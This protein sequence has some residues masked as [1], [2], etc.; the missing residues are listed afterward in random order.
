MKEKGHQSTSS[1]AIEN[2]HHQPHLH[3]QH[4]QQYDQ[5][6]VHMQ[7]QQQQSGQLAASHLPVHKTLTN[8]VL[9]L[10]PSDPTIDWASSISH[11][12]LHRSQSGGVQQQQVQYRLNNNNNNSTTNGH[13]T[14]SFH[15]SEPTFRSHS[16]SYMNGHNSTMA[17]QSSVNRHHSTTNGSSNSLGDDSSIHHHNMEANNN[18]VFYDYRLNR[19]SSHN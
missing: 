16:E 18:K 10:P 5:F 4:Q 12:H 1:A 19:A 9:V 15:N 8:S 17:E 7:Q 3:L 2:R 13:S 11:P 6:N 14:S